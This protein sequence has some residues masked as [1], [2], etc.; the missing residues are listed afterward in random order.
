MGLCVA[1]TWPYV[2]YVAYGWLFFGALVQLCQATVLLLLGPQPACSLLC[3]IRLHTGECILRGL[4]TGEGS[5]ILVEQIC[6]PPRSTC[7]LW[8]PC[9]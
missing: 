3:W 1:Q 4:Q 2:K 9:G 6:L 7:F 5:T 8:I